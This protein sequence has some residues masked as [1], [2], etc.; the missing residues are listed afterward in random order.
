MYHTAFDAISAS[1]IMMDMLLGLLIDDAPNITGWHQIIRVREEPCAYYRT[2]DLIDG[3]DL[4]PSYKQR[5]FAK[6]VTMKARVH[7]EKHHKEIYEIILARTGLHP[8]QFTH[9]H[10]YFY[11]MART[12]G[13]TLEVLRTLH[14]YHRGLVRSGHI[15]ERAA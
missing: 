15:K 2:F 4:G 10:D 8:V 13:Y 3:E 14:S 11:A 9:E 6:G 12:S 7:W 1:S 5:Q